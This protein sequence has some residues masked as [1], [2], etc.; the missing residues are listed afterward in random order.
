LHGGVAPQLVQNDVARGVALQLDDD[1]HAL[2]VGFVADVGNAFQTLFAHHFGDAFDQGLFVDL[3]GQFGDDDGFAILADLFHRGAAA[4]DD[5]TATVAQRIARGGAAHDLAAGGEVGTGH[6]VQQGVVRHV[7]VV[8]QRQGRIDDLAQIVRRDI[9]RHADGDA[10]RAVDQQVRDPARQ[11][12][13]LQLLFVVVGLEIDGVLVDIGH[14]GDGGRGHP[15]LGVTH[16]SGHIAVD[17]AEVPLAVDQHQPHREGL[18]H[19]HQGHIDRG[20]AVG[21]EPAQN[22]ADHTGAFRIAALGCHVQVVHRIEDATVNR[23]E[24]VSG[25][26][27]GAA[28]D[29]AHGVVEVRTL[30]FV[31]DR[32]RGNVGAAA[33][34]IDR[35]CGVFVAVVGQ[36]SVA[37]CGRNRNVI[38]CDDF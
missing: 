31:L 13:R 9:G 21:V 27:Q 36:G 34:A 20:V 38:R 32:D 33:P 10:A 11:D 16:R 37:L 17:R 29:H 23:L 8:Q 26:R 18:G 6:D 15:R 19:P 14:Q 30:Q 4:H 24:A 25:V 3:I 28:D 1:P 12:D 7:G 35:S 5:R 22:V 2:A